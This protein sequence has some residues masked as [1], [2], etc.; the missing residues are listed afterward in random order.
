MRPFLIA[1]LVAAL[2]VS[3][4]D[5]RSRPNAPIPAATMLALLVW[6]FCTPML[7][8]SLGMLV[9]AW[10]WGD[11]NLALAALP[12]LGTA[13]LLLFPWPIT[14]AI[15]IPLGQIRLSAILTHLAMWT[16]RRDVRGGAAVAA[17]WAALRRCQSGR[18]L[19][20]Q[21][22]AWVE[23]RIE[24]R[25]RGEVRWKF[26]GA[27]IV[28]AG[29][30]A[31][32]RNDEASARRLL[33]SAGDTH[34]STRPRYAIEV[35]WSWLCA[36][37]IERGAW[38]EVEFRARTAPTQTRTTD[39]LGSVAARLIGADPVPHD[40][41]LQWQWFAAPNRLATFELLRRALRAPR[42]REDAS[43]R[44]DADPQPD[45]EPDEDVS[46]SASASEQAGTARGFAPLSHA[47]Q[48]H[49]R[50][51]SGS[52]SKLGRARLIELAQAWDAVFEDEDLGA[53]IELR[54]EALGAHAS[55]HDP[56]ALRET[57][58]DDLLG[59]IHDAGL[60]LGPLGEHS[61][62]LGR[63]ARRLHGE[64]LDALEVS[65][66]ALD[67]RVDTE[68]E[69]PALAEWQ[70]FLAIR[71][72]YT[73]AVS[74]GGLSLRRLAFNIVHGPLC[75]Q[76]VW[77]WNDRSERAVGNA[78]FQWLLAEAIIVD[79]SKAITLQEKNVGCGV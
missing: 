54:G 31:A 2:L 36:M 16:W 61:E 17:A 74:L 66:G 14:R 41:L 33:L 43:G 53:H 50:A 55:E 21:Q 73:E 15:L 4:S 75:S 12:W 63:A 6:M 48:L 26:G 45:A 19:T 13:V 49:A 40:L 23:A 27:G 5:N 72:Q 35:A 78:I 22:L 7:L 1:G 28:A 68:R 37:D 60:E 39:F 32:A 25:V 38:E 30:L 79:D 44:E 70:D 59:M 46:S 76:A 57:V 8:I 34:Q 29:L 56:S 71:E 3:G 24:P 64:L 69:L 58:R 47:M 52:P 51:L 20:P 9:E 10:R 62:L 77:L 11:L 18:S 42:E 65:V 67:S